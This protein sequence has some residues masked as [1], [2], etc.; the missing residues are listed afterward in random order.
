MKTFMPVFLCDK[1]SH[2]SFCREKSSLLLSFGH[3][4]L[5]PLLQDPDEETK[6]WQ[7]GCD[8]AEWFVVVR[9]QKRRDRGQ[10]FLSQG[11]SRDPHRVS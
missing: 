11:I 2:S 7:V 9:K 1:T 6:S 4:Q 10:Q 8:R 5:S 3:G